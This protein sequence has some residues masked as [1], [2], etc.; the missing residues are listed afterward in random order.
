[1]H[2]NFW[3]ILLLKN[4][5]VTKSLISVEVND[6]LQSY[7]DQY[8]GTQRFILQTLIQ[9]LFLFRCVHLYAQSTTFCPKVM[10]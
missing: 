3:C 6:V 5:C 1:M 2:H 8:I 9:L 4:V 10:S 7:L